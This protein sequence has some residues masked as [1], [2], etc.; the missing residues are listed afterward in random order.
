MG[1]SFQLLEKPSNMVGILVQRAIAHTV[2]HGTAVREEPNET[3]QLIKLDGTWSMLGS[4]QTVHFEEVI[5]WDI[6]VVTGF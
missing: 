1:Q 2:V 6:E 5:L 3:A 4:A